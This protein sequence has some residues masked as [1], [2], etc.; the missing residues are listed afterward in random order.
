M[1]V[2]HIKLQGSGHGDT[3]MAV[4]LGQDLHLPLLYQSITSNAYE[5]DSRRGDLYLIQPYVINF[6]KY[7]H[8]PVFH[9]KNKSEHHDINEK[10]L[11]VTVNALNC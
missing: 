1:F 6:I 8:T 3:I 5:F 11:T 4:V 10:L 2:D 9:T 7:L